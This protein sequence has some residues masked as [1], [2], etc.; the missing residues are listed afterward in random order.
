MNT[1]I[2]LTQSGSPAVLQLA[3]PET[4]APAA[5]DVW[6]EQAAIGV[7]YLDVMQRNGAVPIP[8]PSGLGLEGAGRV[9]AV[10]D[11]V[12]TVRAGDRVA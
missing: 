12:S 11:G 8:L 10:G 1:E 9:T 2:R 6:L 4:A 5:G 7:N 3:H